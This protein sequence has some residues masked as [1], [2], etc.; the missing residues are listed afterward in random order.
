[1]RWDFIGIT[2]AFAG[3]ILLALG[4]IPALIFG[5]GILWGQIVAVTHPVVKDSLGRFR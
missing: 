5:A 1:M 2:I 4:I 3:I